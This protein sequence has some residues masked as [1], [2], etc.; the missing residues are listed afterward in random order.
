M[1]IHLLG[2]N[3]SN[4]KLD[5]LKQ[6]TINKTIF[7]G[8]LG[9]Y[10]IIKDKIEL[11][12]HNT[13]SPR[14]V[15][16]YVDNITAFIEQIPWIKIQSINYLPIAHC[17]VNIQIKSYIITKQLRLCIEYANDNPA[18]ID[19]YFVSDNQVNPNLIRKHIHSFIVNSK[20]T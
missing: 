5:D 1:R 7:L 15:P 10:E 12:K 11:F 4:F 6:N 17:L 8:E 3:I 18:I 9:M 19:W 20:K 16:H 14:K 2:V 13:V